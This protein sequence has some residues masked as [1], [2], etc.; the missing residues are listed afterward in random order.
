MARLL[1]TG[2]TGLIGRSVLSG[3]LERH[4]DFQI[5]ALVRPETDK[6]RYAAFAGAIDVIPMDLGDIHGLKNYLRD[7]EFDVILHIGA[8]RGGRRF[9][10]AEYLKSN[11][12]STEQI[13]EYCKT[14]NCKLIFCSS[15]G[16]FGAIPEELPANNETPRNPDNYYHYTK[17][18]AEKLI[19]RAVLNGLN[20]AVLRPSITYGSGDQ[21]FPYQLVKLVKTHRFPM[22]NKRT[23]IHL[24]HVDT[25]TNAFLWLLSNEFQPGLA[26][27]VADR[28]PVQLNDLVN[29]ISRQVHGKS[30]HPL[31]TFDRKFFRWGEAVA[32]LLKNELWVSRFQLI[33]RSWFYGVREAYELMGIPETFTI[34][35]IQI[36][37]KDFLER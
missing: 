16:V 34:P 32:R 27:N 29:F 12:L 30:Y 18:E 20:A 21:G 19:N 36:T 15:V 8:L 7:S 33:S 10:K 3:I 28:E 11:L 23:W 25:I 1:I 13:I 31:L 24:C 22:I 2:I 9:P 6:Q 5:T 4:L 37:I 35:G 26:L 17:I 14:K